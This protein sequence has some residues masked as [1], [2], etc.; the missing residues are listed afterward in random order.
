MLCEDAP[1]E[2]ARLI[3]RGLD[4][5]VPAPKGKLPSQETVPQCLGANK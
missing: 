3:A 2:Q 1:A 5:G 4:A